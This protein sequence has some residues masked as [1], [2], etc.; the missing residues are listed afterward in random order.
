MNTDKSRM[1][2][3]SYAAHKLQAIVNSQKI[4]EI[5]MA[6]LPPVS[7]HL[8]VDHPWQQWPGPEQ[9]KNG[10]SKLL[11]QPYRFI[12]VLCCVTA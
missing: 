4:A 8:A 12:V 7:F 2:D 5:L 9:V 6:S 1:M 10:M 3:C 11:T